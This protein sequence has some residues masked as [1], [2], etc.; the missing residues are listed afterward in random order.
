MKKIFLPLAAI[1]IA[2]A[3]TTGCKNP[4]A[5]CNDSAAADSAATAG[6]KGDVAARL[7]RIGELQREIQDIQMGLQEELVEKA[8]TLSPKEFAAYYEQLCNAQIDLQQK[9]DPKDEA[10]EERAKK[11][12]EAATA[13]DK[14]QKMMESPEVK[15]VD[16]RIQQRMQKMFE[17]QMKQQMQM[18]MAPAN[19]SLT[20]A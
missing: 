19:D 11:L 7:N 9:K 14:V 18:Q 20:T 12:Q 6:A 5:S 4:Y 17:E 16:E 3:C 1:A 15:A 13:D 10:M 2:M 8:Q